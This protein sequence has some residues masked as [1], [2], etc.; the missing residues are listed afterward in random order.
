VDRPDAWPYSN[1]LEWIDKRL[2]T[3][4]DRQLGRD[5]FATPQAYEAFVEELVECHT[6]QEA[7]LGRAWSFLEGVKPYRFVTVL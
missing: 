5:Y 6:F 2:G 1:Y 3:L 7:A 4:V